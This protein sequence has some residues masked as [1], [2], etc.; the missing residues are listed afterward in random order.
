MKYIIQSGT[1]PRNRFQLHLLRLSLLLPI[2][3][4]PAAASAATADGFVTKINSKMAFNVGTLHVALNAQTT[5]K[6]RIGSF[7]NAFQGT[8][9]SGKNYKRLNAVSWVCNTSHV[10]VGSRIHLYGSVRDGDHFIAKRMVVYTIR[11]DRSIENGAIIEEMP[12]VHQDSQH[13]SGHLWIDGYPISVTSQT[14]MLMANPSSYFRETIPFSP[15]NYP[16]LHSNLHSNSGAVYDGAVSFSSKLLQPNICATYSANR[17]IDGGITATQL[18]FWPNH[19]SIKEEFFLNIFKANVIDPAYKRHTPGSIKLQSRQL[20][21]IK[22]LSIIPDRTVQDWVSNVGMELVPQYQR[23]LPDTDAT[24]VHFRFYVVK[25]FK[26]FPYGSMTTI[27]GASFRV[28]YDAFVAMPNGIV[29]IPDNALNKLQNKSQLAALLSYEISAVL[30]KQAYVTRMLFRQGG[31]RREINSGVWLDEQTLRIG[32]RQMYLAGYD[33]REAPFAWAVAQGKPVNN[34]ILNSKHPDK[35]IPWYAAYAFNYISHYYKD[36]DYSKLKRG[37][38]EYQQFL[39][40]LY[41]ADPSLPRPKVA[42]T[43]ASKK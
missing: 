36:V 19:V 33:I 21:G 26:R 1:K 39:Q 28:F 38:K 15:W 25:P 14:R 13:W 31:V 22:E 7:S 24:K 40:E 18:R 37:E 16:Q 10:A 3:L 11:E 29:I 12:K 27:D 34:P 32:I 23:N 8:Y 43:P 6:T 9:I 30:Q 17:E 4:L 35:E 2:A 5:C 20:R 42:T 41:K